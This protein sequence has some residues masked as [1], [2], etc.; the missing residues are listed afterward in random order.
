MGLQAT[1]AKSRS[2]TDRC[3]G[4]QTGWE[5]EAD[6]G[7]TD[8]APGSAFPGRVEIVVDV[9]LAV[10]VPTDQDEPVDLDQIVGGSLLDSVPITLRCALVRVRSDVQVDRS[11]DVGSHGSLLLIRRA[12]PHAV[13]RTSR[14]HNAAG[15][16]GNP[17]PGR[18]KCSE[19]RA[20]PG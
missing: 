6:D 19:P 3:A 9:D 14:R 1:D 11:L 16:R 12:Q 18:T 17:H 13:R 20:T 10:R 8:R 2:R 15:P 7:T 5:D 4:Q